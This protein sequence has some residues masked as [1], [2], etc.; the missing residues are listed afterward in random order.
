MAS[1]ERFSRRRRALLERLAQHSLS[2]AAGGPPAAVLFAAPVHHRN[3]DV[4]HP[5][6]ADSDLAYLT[7]FEEPDAV[8]V[9]L[10]GRAEG[11][12]VLFLRARDLGFSGTE[13]PADIEAATAATDT[14]E[15]ARAIVAERLNLV[16]DR[17]DA[18]RLTPGLP[19]VGFVAEP[20]DYTASDGS[21]VR[22]DEVDVTGRLM[23]M[24][25]AHRSY[26]T[27]GAIA[28][29][30]AAFVPGSLVADAVRR[31]DERPEPDTIRI[32]H[33]YGV[34]HAVVRATDP[35]DPS[36]I[37]GIAVGRTAHHILDGQVW[38]RRRVL[39]GG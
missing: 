25:T 22:A 33:P 37:Q 1:F 23:S 27:T 36:T 11:E 14:L 5:Y 19:K 4:E 20:L 3:S 29:A 10:P 21:T 28:T 24:Q 18:T 7:G 32:A 35:A 17:K 15:E 31:R 8:L 9:L 16:A 13:L 12:S 34:M 30:A 26:M 39:G 38:V 2:A 6:R